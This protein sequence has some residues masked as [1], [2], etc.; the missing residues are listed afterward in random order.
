MKVD[1]LIDKFN[2]DNF[3]DA[4]A[5]TEKIWRIFRTTDELHKL[6]YDIK[7]DVFYLDTYP[8]DNTK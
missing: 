8:I 2:K 3:I 4:G 1:I 7:Y 5:D 6:F